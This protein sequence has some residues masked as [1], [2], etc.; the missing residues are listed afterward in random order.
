MVLAC[1]RPIVQFVY[2]FQ[3][4]YSNLIKVGLYFGS[5]HF[6]KHK[7]YE[8]S[9]QVVEVSKFVSDKQVRQPVQYDF[10]LVYAIPYALDVVFQCNCYSYFE[11]IL[12]GLSN[13][14]L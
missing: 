12:C 8:V 2:I 6:T 4:Y 11:A 9:I 5:C 7:W 1:N 3:L 10:Y 13:V 14:L